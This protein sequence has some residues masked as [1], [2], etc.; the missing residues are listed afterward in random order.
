[1][2]GEGIALPHVRTMQARALAA[3][4]IVWREGIHLDAPD[5]E[6]IRLVL[7]VVSPPYDD[8]TYLKLYKRL[9]H[10]LQDEELLEWLRYVEAPGEVVRILARV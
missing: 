4:A 7:A 2:L 6:P 5:D 9:G 1:M 3:A 10:A 8:Q